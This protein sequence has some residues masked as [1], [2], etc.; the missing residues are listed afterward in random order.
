MP[1]CMPDSST[2][3]ASL[4]WLQHAPQQIVLHAAYAIAA[5][6]AAAY[7]TAAAG[8]TCSLPHHRHCAVAMPS[9]AMLPS[10]SVNNTFAVYSSYLSLGILNT[11][12]CYPAWLMFRLL[13]VNSQDCSWPFYS[14]SFLPLAQQ[15]RSQRIHSSPSHVACCSRN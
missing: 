11:I 13:V 10:L 4:L 2:P 12:E 14:P 6:P 15:F 3:R 8:S 1:P 9:L 5:C 7:P